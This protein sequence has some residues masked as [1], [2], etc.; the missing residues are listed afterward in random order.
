MAM[1]ILF[2]TTLRNFPV[3]SLSLVTHLLTSAVA[4]SSSMFSFFSS[5]LT[6]VRQLQNRPQVGTEID[7]Y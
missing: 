2:S 4:S 1:G 3:L 6:I 7:V 5:A